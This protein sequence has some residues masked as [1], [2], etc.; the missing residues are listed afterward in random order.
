MATAVHKTTKRARPEDGGI[1]W[2]ERLHAFE[3]QG[4]DEFEEVHGAHNREP[5]RLAELKEL[6]VVDHTECWEFDDPRMA[7]RRAE[8]SQGKEA[9]R[10]PGGAAGGMAGSA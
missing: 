5:D 2:H 4:C 10:E 8:V 1:V 6:L 3:C 7:A 9:P